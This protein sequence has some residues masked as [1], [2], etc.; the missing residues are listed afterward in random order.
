MNNCNQSNAPGRAY[1]MSVK[2]LDKLMQKTLIPL[3]WCNVFLLELA[4]VAYQW[5]YFA[6]KLPL[7]DW[8][9]FKVIWPTFPISF[10]FMPLV[11]SN[12]IWV[13]TLGIGVLQAIAISMDIFI[14]GVEGRNHLGLL[15][16]IVAT[17]PA[18]LLIEAY[19]IWVWLRHL[20]RKNG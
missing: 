1:H 15:D 12:R 19:A 8:C 13:R 20:R 14:L 16:F 11:M 9:T 6:V 3:W 18:S 10:T 17:V 2:S 7:L 4:V 5:E